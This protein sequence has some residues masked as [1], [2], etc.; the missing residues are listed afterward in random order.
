MAIESAKEILEEIKPDGLT[1]MEFITYICNICCVAFYLTNFHAFKFNQD[2]VN[3][4]SNIWNFDTSLFLFWIAVFFL[5]IDVV[6]FEVKFK[7]DLKYDVINWR[8]MTKRLTRLVS[9]FISIYLLIMVLLRID[10]KEFEDLSNI[11]NIFIII[12]IFLLSLNFISLTSDI[13]KER[14]YGLEAKYEKKEYLRNTINK[15]ENQSNDE[16]QKRILLYQLYELTSKL[17][18]DGIKLDEDNFNRRKGI[19]K[20]Q[21]LHKN[22]RYK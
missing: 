17:Y 22:K 11:Q 15:F 3:F 2:T 21:E 6:Q 8:V 19:E 20:M 5:I 9:L 4:I 10:G 18:D 7:F 16:I 12:Y 14:D 1:I 13:F